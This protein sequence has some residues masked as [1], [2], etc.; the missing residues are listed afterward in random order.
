ME[1]FM[2]GE[3]IGCLVGDTTGKNEGFEV[4]CSLGRLVGKTNG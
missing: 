4:G 1:G 3:V 2:V